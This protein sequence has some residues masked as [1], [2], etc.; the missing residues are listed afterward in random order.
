MNPLCKICGNDT[1][2]HDS[3]LVLH[4][5]KVTYYFCPNCGF[6]Q[7]EEPYWLEEAYSKAIAQADT[8]IMS[9]NLTNASS[10]L[11]FMQFMDRGPCLDF[12]G[13]HGILTRI[14]RDYGFDFYHYDKYA[15]NLFA[16]G[17]EGNLDKTYKLITAF[18]NFE[19][20]VNPLEEIE[21]LVSITDILFFSTTLLSCP[22]PSPI[23]D[24]WYY[25]PDTGQHISFYSKH[26]L[27][28][29]AKKYGMNLLS[30]NCQTHILSNN[31]INKRFF[32]LLKIY[33]KINNISITRFFK[34]KSKAWDD[35]NAILAQRRDN[36]SFI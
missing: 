2:V 14:M 16:C 4:K 34:R 22:L 6:V 24:W 21:K 19:H 31:K 18:E 33:N 30:D 20:F 15:E 23:M 29:I 13:G 25:A 28:F 32:L 5:Y 10:L 7:T 3:A 26:A 27:Q 12:G 36:E 9:R 1:R 35:M 17:F 8:G 11:L